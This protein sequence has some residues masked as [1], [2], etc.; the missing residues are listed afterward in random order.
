[1]LARIAAPFVRPLAIALWC[2]LIACQVAAFSCAAPPHR[3]SVAVFA[4]PV[5]EQVLDAVIAR[6]RADRARLGLPAKDDVEPKPI[7]VRIVRTAADG[8]SPDAE[9]RRVACQVTEPPDPPEFSAFARPGDYED[10]AI[11]RYYVTARNLEDVVEWYKQMH[12]F[13]VDV[14]VCLRALARDAGEP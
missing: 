9:M 12:Q 4:H 1:M 5:H 3:A 14:G 8:P 11:A 10:G 7:T 6:A 13:S 2:V